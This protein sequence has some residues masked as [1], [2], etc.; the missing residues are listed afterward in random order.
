MGAAWD[1]PGYDVEEL[2]GFGG[3][4]EVWR[5]REVATGT[6]VALKRLRAADPSARDRLRREAAL[7]SSVAGDHVV[8]IRDVITTETEAVL[9]MDFAAGGSLAGILAIRGRLAAPEVVTLVGPLASALA[10]AHDGGVVHGDVTPANIVFTADGRPLLTD[11]GIARVAGAL[12]DALDQVQATAPYAA[13]EVLAGAVP[14]AA[15]DVFGLCRVAVEALDRATAPP[16]LVEAIEAGLAVD[17]HDRPTARS[18]A[19]D[20]LS[21]CAAAPVGLVRT[22]PVAPPVVTTTVRARPA[23]QTRARTPTDRRRRRRSRR[24]SSRAGAAPVLVALALLGAVAGGVVWGHH[25]GSTAAA[26]PAVP[27]AAATDP[28]W[29]RVV[30]QLDEARARALTQADPTLL[31]EVYADGSATGGQDRTTLLRLAARGWR[32]SGFRELTTAVTPVLVSPDDVTLRVTGRLAAYTLVDR[33]SRVVRRLAAGHERTF[34]MA[35]V[36]TPDGWRV[37]QVRM[38][39]SVSR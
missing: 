27:P 8:R 37:R 34:T 16:A 26:L 25:S 18:L 3:S 9:V 4:G 32:A 10:D 21:V 1:L 20:V 11:F 23:P 6:V 30:Q 12:G 19:M 7:V 31:D 24:R 22:A 17:P 29:L 2:V 14:T 39:S 36:R 33:E 5:A 35:L 38:E 13:P 28:D 15:A